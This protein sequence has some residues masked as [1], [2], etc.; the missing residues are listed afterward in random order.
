MKGKGEGRKGIDGV[1]GKDPN[2]EKG[3]QRRSTIECGIGNPNSIPFLA[4][5]EQQKQR[6]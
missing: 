4:P 1:D 3:E 6:F 2:W 5:C